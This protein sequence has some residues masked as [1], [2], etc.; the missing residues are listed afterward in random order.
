MSA[1]DLAWSVLKARFYT[2]EPPRTKRH[3]PLMRIPEGFGA[4]R[5]PRSGYH[6]DLNQMSNYDLDQMMD[7]MPLDII[8]NQNW[9]ERVA[10]QREQGR[11][12]AK[13]PLE[14]ETNRILF[15]IARPDS[16]QYK[17]PEDEMYQ[18]LPQDAYPEP[19]PSPRP[20]TPGERTGASW[21]YNYG[22]Q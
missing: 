14:G 1:F 21:K 13:L 18:E 12:N 2:N 17:S 20:D 8:Q 15:P 10:R 5:Q 16:P 9:R 3:E 7:N 4:N 19:Q 6:E 11:I 22:G